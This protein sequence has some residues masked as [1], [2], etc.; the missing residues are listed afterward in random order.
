MG[1]LVMQY[2]DGLRISQVHLGSEEPFSTKQ[3]AYS[4]NV[5]QTAYD[6]LVNNS[7]DHSFIKR[8]SLTTEKPAMLP[9]WA[10]IDVVMVSKSCDC[11]HEL[12][13]EALLTHLNPRKIFVITKDGQCE[14]LNSFHF[15]QEKV[16][17]L[18]EGSAVPG[19]SLDE[20]SKGFSTLERKGIC[21]PARYDKPP[22]WF[23]QQF[24]KLGFPTTNPEISDYFLVWDADM[25]ITDSYDYHDDQGRVVYPVG[26]W[27]KD[28]IVYKPASQNIMSGADFAEGMVTHHMM[29]HKPYLAELLDLFEEAKLPQL[30][31]NET[32]LPLWA[33]HA[34]MSACV[35][36]EKHY[37]GLGF[38]EY[39]MYAT[40][41]F[42]YHS[43]NVRVADA[44]MAQKLSR[45]GGNNILNHCMSEEDFNKRAK[46]L[47]P[48]HL[49][50]GHEQ[51]ESVP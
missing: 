3:E 21:N 26:G 51:H 14:K 8:S 47:F 28:K 11:Y 6:I 7:I 40:F 33:Q 30:D 17:C 27:D 13:L 42:N 48:G 31:K 16:S 15:P 29:M 39:A 10:D 38:S 22:G 46:Q 4:R 18:D 45:Q 24:L 50:V 36:N 32:S 23:L 1:L 49:I 19:L 35:S 20:V 9:A 41:V 2:A 25:I 37:R 44:E 5:F 34:M 43:A 12:A